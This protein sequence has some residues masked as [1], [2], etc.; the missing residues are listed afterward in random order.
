MKEGKKETRILDTINSPA[1]LK[2]LNLQELEQLAGEIREKIVPSK[3][4][5]QA[6]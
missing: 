5:A 6:K 3:P 1:D 2:E 4:S